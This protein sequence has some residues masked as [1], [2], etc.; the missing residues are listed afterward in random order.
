MPMST[1]SRSDDKKIAMRV[2]E[3][4]HELVK[5]IMDFFATGDR[6]VNEIIIVPLIIVARVIR[7]HRA[8]ELLVDEGHP[9]EAAILAL[10]QFELRLDLA[11]TAV[12]V[13]RAAAWLEHENT[14]WSLLPVK[15]KIA[16]LFSSKKEREM[17]GD[18]FEYLSG[19]KH[20]NPIFSELGFP[21]R[22]EG[23]HFVVTTGEIDDELTRSFGDLLFAY[24]AYQLAWSSQ[25]LNVHTA[26]YASVKKALRVE[27]Q[28]LAKKLHPVEEEL[29]TY[30]EA[31]VRK[32]PGH[33][34]IK[35][36][37]TK[38]RPNN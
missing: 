14:K 33:L 24:S 32:R 3:A 31:L 1:R 34:G 36:W 7:T 21:V 17:L 2:D 8:I 4:A 12:D 28:E 10:T 11:Y 6:T 19:I 18:V 37:R 38:T 29:H 22:S 16:K 9:T 30:C 26:Q 13:K 23:K 20:G 25:V 15:D 35:V 5:E 27:I